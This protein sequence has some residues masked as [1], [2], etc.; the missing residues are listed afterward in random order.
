MRSLRYIKKSISHAR[1]ESKPEAD[2][3]VLR[4]LLVEFRTVAG[5]APVPLKLP[6]R[7]RVLQA[8]AAAAL[9]VLALVIATRS[10]QKTTTPSPANR[11]ESAGD[12]L[13]VGHL[14]AAYRRGGL[15]AVD[16]QCEA[17]ARKLEDRP[18][19]ISVNQL[20]GELNGI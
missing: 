19:R 16:R 2:Q 18:L 9:V 7:G 4:H 11:I 1:V 14:N 15:E 10:P 8:V 5:A 20:I 12:L 6:V 3:A 13:T 17:A